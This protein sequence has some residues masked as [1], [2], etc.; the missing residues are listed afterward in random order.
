[1]FDVGQK[2][3]CI[4]DQ[5]DASLRVDSEMGIFNTYPKKDLTYT[6]RGWD[7]NHTGIYL[8]EIRNFPALY[9]N[10]FGE[11]S[12]RPDKFVRIEDIDE[13]NEGVIELMESL[14][15]AA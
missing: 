2:V 15:F 10:G 8:E 13:V 3:V 9:S 7:K 5:F 1:M 14:K 11:R 12:F 4:D 6:V